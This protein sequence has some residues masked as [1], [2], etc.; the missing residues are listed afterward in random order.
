MNERIDSQTLGTARARRRPVA[1]ALWWGWHALVGWLVAR[2]LVATVASSYGSHVDGDAPLRND[3]GLALLDWLANTHAAAGAIGAYGSLIVPLLLALGLGPMAFVIA[4][5]GASD[6][7]DWREMARR[8]AR[9]LP[10]LGLLF[11]GWCITVAIVVA[12]F[13]WSASSIADGGVKSSDETAADLSAFGVSIFGLFVLSV[14]GVV[15]DLARTATVDRDVGAWHALRVGVRAFRSAPFAT[16]AGWA[17]RAALSLAALLVAGYL[18][19]RGTGDPSM[20]AVVLAHQ[21]ALAT[22]TG[23]RASWL[24]HALRASRDVG[25]VP[26]SA[27]A[28]LARF[29]RASGH[30]APGEQATAEEIGPPISRPRSTETPPSEGADAQAAAAISSAPEENDPQGAGKP[31]PASS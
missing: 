29:K 16:Y 13:A 3:G 27:R 14:F 31:P 30:A 26:P 23:L 15:H 12:I 20:V 18:V 8:A 4:A 19:D 24:A 21:G 7:A 22:R 25:A 6:S 9:A 2:P 1:I 17:W 5:V 28:L 11:L 10:A